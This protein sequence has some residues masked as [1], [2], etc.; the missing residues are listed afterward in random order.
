MIWFEGK[1]YETCIKYNTSNTGEESNDMQLHFIRD[2][3]RLIFSEWIPL[4]SLV[5][6]Y[7]RDVRCN[8]PNGCVS[9]LK[10]LQ[11]SKDKPHSVDRHRR[12]SSA[13]VVCE[14]FEL[15]RTG[16][17]VS[18]YEENNHIRHSQLERHFTTIKSRLHELQSSLTERAIVSNW[19]YCSSTVLRWIWCSHIDIFW[20]FTYSIRY[21]SIY[22]SRIIS[23]IHKTHIY[24]P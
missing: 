11:Q 5:L 13:F 12:L 3:L 15:R 18:P 22:Q 14:R 17:F 23:L 4:I 1:Y 7:F 6:I 24:R 19:I 10:Q 20:C 8:L 16:V 2:S 9:V 21:Y